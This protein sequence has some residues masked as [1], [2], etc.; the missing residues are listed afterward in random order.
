MLAVNRIICAKLIIPYIPT[1]FNIFFPFGDFIPKYYKNSLE[2]YFI[3]G[4][5]IMNNYMER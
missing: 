1:Q 3:Y 2:I 5:L 4:I